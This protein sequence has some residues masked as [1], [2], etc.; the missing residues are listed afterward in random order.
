MER[1][2]VVALAAAYYEPMTRRDLGEL[3][4]YEALSPRAGAAATATKS[5][6]AN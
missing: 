3:S 2:S 4:D 1:L 5:D 6:D